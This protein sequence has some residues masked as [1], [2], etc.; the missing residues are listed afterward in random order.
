[1]INSIPKILTACGNK[2]DVDRIE[3]FHFFL[4][5]AGFDPVIE[6][7]CYVDQNRNF[8]VSENCTKI[9]QFHPPEQLYAFVDSD[10]V[11]HP[12]LNQ[13][14]TMMISFLDKSYSYDIFGIPY[15]S[16][17]DNG[18]DCCKNKIGQYDGIVEVGEIGMGCTAI[19]GRVFNA[20]RYP[21]FQRPVVEEN[22]DAFLMGEDIF[23]TRVA[24]K[25]GFKIFADY[26]TKII[27]ILRKDELSHASTAT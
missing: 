17:A 18:L 1:M 16:Q 13:A 26:G 10:I 2:A 23:F 21:Y 4:A 27:H 19:K 12:D 14:V 8:L 20:M 6:L 22:G 24:R 15:E 5:K 11:L 25:K 7:G 3:P 9:F